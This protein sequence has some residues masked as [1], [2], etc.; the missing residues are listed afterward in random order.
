MVRDPTQTVKL[1]HR[2]KQ[3]DLSDILGPHMT[4]YDIMYHMNT[5]LKQ[6]CKCFYIILVEIVNAFI[7]SM[8]VTN[9]SWS[10]IQCGSW[11]CPFWILI[12]PLYNMTWA[13][14]YLC[15]QNSLRIRKDIVG[16]PLRAVNRPQMCVYCFHVYL[17]SLL[18]CPTKLQ[19]SIWFQLTSKI[20]VKHQNKA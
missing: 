15:S 10:I 6:L 2:V 13:S 1:D 8:R 14:Y 7:A 17:S 12:G 4:C 5:V 9:T 19:N 11:S 3:G 20:L 18:L 16:Q